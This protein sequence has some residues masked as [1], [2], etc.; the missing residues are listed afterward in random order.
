MSPA[1]GNAL[2]L[3]KHSMSPQSPIVTVKLTT[4]L[5]TAMKNRE[6]LSLTRPFIPPWCMLGW[7]E[8]MMMGNDEKG[9]WM[10]Q[11]WRLQPI[12]PAKFLALERSLELR[13]DDGRPCML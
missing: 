1:P 3:P 5:T 8:W 13:V 6:D 12:S 2:W 9:R 11:R 7:M 4:K 10:D